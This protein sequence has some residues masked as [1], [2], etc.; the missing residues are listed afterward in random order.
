MTFHHF[1]LHHTLPSL[2]LVQ[3]SLSAPLLS[4]TTDP[5]TDPTASTS[6]LPASEPPEP[7]DLSRTPYVHVTTE[8]YLGGIADLTGELMRLAI[9]SV[10]RSLGA[11]EGEGD[12]LA[13]VAG[14]AAFVRE[15]KGG[16]WG[17]FRISVDGS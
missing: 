4:P 8:D 11:R 15:I 7:L 3:A 9:G 10:G 6:A 17:S 13:S 12:G 14:I 16:T 5:S 2:E 1:L